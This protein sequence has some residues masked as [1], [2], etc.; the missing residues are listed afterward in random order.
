MMANKYGFFLAFCSC[1]NLGLKL[2]CTLIFSFV[3]VLI[4]LALF[5]YFY[6]FH[7]K[8]GQT[9]AAVSTTTDTSARVRSLLHRLVDAI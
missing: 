1:C 3:G 4:I 2:L 5:I 7:N 8:S 9:T 6:F